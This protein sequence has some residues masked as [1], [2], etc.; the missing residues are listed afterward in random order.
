MIGAAEKVVGFV[1]GRGR[2]DLN[3]DDMLQF[4][5]IHG[6]AIIG[7]AAAK[8]SAA[9]QNATPAIPWRNIIGMRNRIVHAYADID[10]ALVWKTATEEL[11]E[12]LSQ[13]RIALG[14]SDP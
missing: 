12:L 6:I 8:V 13:L 2:G 14:P 11:P 1:A 10:L 4:A 3:Q 9:T 5:C 7:E